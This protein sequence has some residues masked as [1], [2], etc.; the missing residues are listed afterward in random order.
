MDG[1]DAGAA[2]ERVH[3][4]GAVYGSLLAASVVAGSAAEG[5]P[6]T[7]AD[8][9]TL[10]IC[11]GVVFWITHVYVQVVGSGY[12]ARPF[13]WGNL[14]TVARSEWPLAQASFPP[15]IAAALASGLGMSNTV[16]AWAA[17]CVAVA[18]QVGWAVTAAV[19]IHASRSVIIVSGI[20]NLILGLAIVAL[21]TLVS[22]H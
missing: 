20:A 5:G 19:Q 4:G 16:A 12:P 7:P 22:G 11:T 6:P 14:R 2:S 10:L 18:S 15:S 1:R 9:V 21:K 13:T 3:S 8:L 17:L